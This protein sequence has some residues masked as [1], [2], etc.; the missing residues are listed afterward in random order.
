M[1]A[2]KAL[3]HLLRAHAWKLSAFSLLEQLEESRVQHAPKELV[4]GVTDPLLDGLG[5]GE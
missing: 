4:A 2:T 3:S 1:P 5:G